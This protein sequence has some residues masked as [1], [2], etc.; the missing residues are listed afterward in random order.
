V[1][2]RFSILGFQAR[3]DYGPR[4]RAGV[5]ENEC[6]PLSSRVA[7]NK[8][9]LSVTALIRWDEKAGL[10]RDAIRSQ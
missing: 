10:Q 9:Q 6:Q 5:P 1:R 3:W 7:G 8:G 2:G 4:L